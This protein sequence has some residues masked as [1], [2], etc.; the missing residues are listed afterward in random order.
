MGIESDKKRLKL[1]RECIGENSILMVD[2]NQVWT[3]KEAIDN[4]IALKDFN[5]YWIEEP[6]CPD[7]ALGHHLIAKEVNKFNIKVATGEHC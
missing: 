1:M 5:L 2:S 4:M 3:V 7:D 6:T